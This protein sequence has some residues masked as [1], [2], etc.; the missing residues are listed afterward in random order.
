MEVYH[1]ATLA[2]A[3]STLIEDLGT[4][5]DEI[6]SLL[7][8][9][10]DILAT[11]DD[12]MAQ[13]NKEM[14]RIVPIPKPIMP[15][16]RGKAAKAIAKRSKPQRFSDNLLDEEIR[17]EVVSEV[18]FPGSD[19]LTPLENTTNTL[20]GKLHNV[21]FHEAELIKKCF[22]TPHV[23]NISCNYGEVVN[24]N[25]HPPVITKTT[26]GRKKKE[27]PP[28][29]RKEQGDGSSFNSQISFAVLPRANPVSEGDGICHT[30][31]YKF[32]VFRPGQ[33]QLPGAKLC[34]LEDIIDR[35]ALMVDCLKKVLGC[36]DIYLYQLNA[37]MKNYKFL[38]KMPRGAILDLNRLKEVM[39]AKKNVFMMKYS[40]QESKLAI[41]FSTPTASDPEKTAR[42]NIFTSGKINILG[43]YENK[44][45][46]EICD[47]F[48]ESLRAHYSHLVLK[49][50]DT[51]RAWEWNIDPVPADAWEK[52]APNVYKSDYLDTWPAPVAAPRNAIIID[53]AHILDLV[54]ELYAEA[55]MESILEWIES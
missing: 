17:K 8:S 25:Y 16:L 49:E 48:N 14:K 29:T 15:Q 37:I 35:S 52:R 9:S 50:N 34:D 5:F 46:K 42:V 30:K 10:P 40:R 51:S 55:E 18:I 39:R 44:Y 53:E 4:A 7:D 21:S 36:D 23:I 22:Y 31:P 28:K 33:V 11:Y 32:K 24:P 3:E 43:A 6:S 13:L 45:T 27:K 41:V 19:I 38:L 47:T 54:E 1:N 26:R 2:G 20:D 12:T